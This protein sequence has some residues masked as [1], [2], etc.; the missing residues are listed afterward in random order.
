[1]TQSE[2]ARTTAHRAVVFDMDGV[3]VQSEHLWERMWSRFAA[4]R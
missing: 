3:L 2:A 4:A 1:M